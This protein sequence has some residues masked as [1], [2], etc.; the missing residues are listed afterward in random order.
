L[1]LP[2]PASGGRSVG[3]VRSRIQAIEFVVL[4]SAK[5]TPCLSPDFKMVSCSTYS[6]TLKMEAVCSFGTSLD[7]QQ[8]MPEDSKQLFIATAVRTSNPAWNWLKD[9][10]NS[11]IM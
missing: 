8:T 9:V 11:G 4:L 6:S 10:S 7:F 2:L 3:I 5:N 1:A